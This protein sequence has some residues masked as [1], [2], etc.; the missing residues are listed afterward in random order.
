MKSLGPARFALGCITSGLVF[1]LLGGG[2]CANAYDR[3]HPRASE[4]TTTAAETTTTRAAD[5]RAAPETLRPIGSGDVA[6]TTMM[7][8]R[9]WEGR[10]PYPASE[11]TKWARQN[12]EAATALASWEANDPEKPRVLI[13]WAIAHPYEDVGVFLINRPGWEEFVRLRAKYPAAFDALVEWARHS[14]RAAEV[15]VTRSVGFAWLRD[16]ANLN[17]L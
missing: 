8:I 9:E 17:T 12:R 7:P 15:L 6:A 14:T 11:L 5:T 4:T 16:R 2:A 1:L 3:A 13:S 10:Y